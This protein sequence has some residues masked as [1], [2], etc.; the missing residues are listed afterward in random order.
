MALA[1][2]NYCHK[3]YD[4]SKIALRGHQLLL[5]EGERK[6]KFLAITNFSQIVWLIFIPVDYFFC[7]DIWDVSHVYLIWDP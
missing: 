1:S 7:L 6:K 5:H 3:V 4:Y 2:G